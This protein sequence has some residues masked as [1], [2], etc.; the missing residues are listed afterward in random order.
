MR[1]LG[2]RCEEF[3]EHLLGYHLNFFLLL[4]EFIAALFNPVTLA[5]CGC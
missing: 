2:K 1:T 5:I 3:P 4:K